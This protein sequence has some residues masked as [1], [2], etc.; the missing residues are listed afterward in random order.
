[1]AWVE[2]IQ[3]KTPRRGGGALLGLLQGGDPS[4]A[5]DE[6]RRHFQRKNPA[7]QRVFVL[8]ISQ[9]KL[10]SNRPVRRRYVQTL[11]PSCSLIGTVSF[12]KQA[13]SPQGRN[14]I[15]RIPQGDIY[16]ARK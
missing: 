12:P 5:S 3:Q 14:K 6:N 10:S 13:S 7:L 4:R 2:G 16:L 11:V 9:L 15:I 1:M 8:H